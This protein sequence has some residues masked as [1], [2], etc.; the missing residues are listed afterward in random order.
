MSR[1]PGS[2]HSRM[3]T[4][5]ALLINSHISPASLTAREKAYMTVA[6]F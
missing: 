3:M 6:V 5:G 2:F 4:T 1:A